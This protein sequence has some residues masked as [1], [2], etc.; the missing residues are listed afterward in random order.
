MR[1]LRCQLKLKID[2]LFRVNF[3]KNLRIHEEYLHIDPARIV[4][5]VEWEQELTR[6]M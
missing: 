6:T 4:S 1:S 5:N 2:C 3:D